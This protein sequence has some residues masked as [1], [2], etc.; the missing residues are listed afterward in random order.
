MPTYLVRVE[1]SDPLSSSDAYAIEQAI[2]ET[3]RVVAGVD[4][5]DARFTATVEPEPVDDDGFGVALLPCGDR[6][7]AIPDVEPGDTVDCL[8][9]DAPRIRVAEI[10]RLAAVQIITAQEG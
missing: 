5:G 9:C 10:E 4:R 7:P 2:F 8:W 1:A 6:I 3:G